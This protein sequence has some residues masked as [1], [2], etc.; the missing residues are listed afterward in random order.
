MADTVDIKKFA[1]I[2]GYSPEYARKLV[3]A[4][5]GPRHVRTGRKIR[6]FVA[7]IE[8]WQ[9]AHMVEPDGN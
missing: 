4:G 5:K 9:K 7:D 3:R 8:A 1:Q 2:T 6:F